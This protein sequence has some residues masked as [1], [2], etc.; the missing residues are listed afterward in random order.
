MTIR[1]WHMILIILL[2]SST[3]CVDEYWPKL[4]KYEDLLVVDG[5]ITNFPGPYTIKLSIS[6]SVDN[7]MYIPFG[8]ATVIIA[9]HLG[10]NEILSETDEGTYTTSLSGIQGIIGRKYR[11]EIETADN[12]NYKSSGKHLS[13]N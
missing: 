12:K 2:L 5:M 7:P 8:G 13:N 4:D 1:L 9:D 6:S 3:A 10:N 11:I